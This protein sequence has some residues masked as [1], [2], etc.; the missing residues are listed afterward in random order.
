VLTSVHA[1]ATDPTRGVFILA[2]L[3]FFIGGSLALFAWRAPA[4]KPGGIFAP[5]SREGALILNNLLLTAAAATVLV[6][7]LYPLALEALT[8]DKISVG[9][10]FFNRTVGPL[11]LLLLMLMP[12]GPLLA[13]KRADA[14]AAA[15]RLTFAAASAFFFAAASLYFSEG[16]SLLA[17]LGLFIA[18]FAVTGA[19]VEL[20]DRI[21]LFREPLGHSLARAAGL[22][23]SAYGTTLAHAGIGLALLGVVA[24]SGWSEERILSLRPGERVPIA[25]FE[26]TF[27][28]MAERVGPNWRDDVGRFEVRRGGALVATAEPAKRVYVA[29]GQPTTE[30][31][32]VTFGLS[33]LYVTIGDPAAGGGISTRI[34]WKPLVLLIW[35]GPVLMALGGMLSLSD[36]RLRIG[37]PRRVKKPAAVPAE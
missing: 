18:V 15:Q 4:L 37:A 35:L 10:P 32:I 22:P 16:G 14:L 36:R 3:A 29:R 31:G 2:I 12:A 28:G 7:T 33:Q 5:V 17:A 19:L 34:Y 24:E 30:A 26:L 21:A 25:Q 8:G 27:A 6:G 20:A 11:L 9:P 23:R 13:W 1:F